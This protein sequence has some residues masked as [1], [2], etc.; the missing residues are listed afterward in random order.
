MPMKIGRRIEPV[1]VSKVLDD[2]W[3]AV[4]RQTDAVIAGS[5]RNSFRVGLDLLTS[6]GR[7]L[8]ESWA[9]Y[10]VPYSLKLRM[11]LEFTSGVR[12]RDLSS[13]GRKGNSPDHQLRSLNSC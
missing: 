6:G 9:Q 7:A 5:L 12:L 3:L 10:W 2:L 4:T 8:I 1:T 11:P 13:V